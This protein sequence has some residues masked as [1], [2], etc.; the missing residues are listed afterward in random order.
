MGRSNIPFN[1]ER[2]SISFGPVEV[3]H[4]GKPIPFNEEAA[5]EHLLGEE[6]IITVQLTDGLGNGTAWGCDLTYDYIRI[7][8][9]YRT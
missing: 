6:V 3:M 1:Q 8:A 7:N 9:S 4:L 2:V 5:K